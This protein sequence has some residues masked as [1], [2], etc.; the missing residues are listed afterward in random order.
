MRYKT[1]N[2]LKSGCTI[3]HGNHTGIVKYDEFE[4][5]YARLSSGVTIRIKDFKNKITIIKG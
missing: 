5:Y 1:R 2:R 4:G 3:R